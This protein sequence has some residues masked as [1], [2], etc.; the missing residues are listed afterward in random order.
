MAPI[1]SG[2]GDVL[3]SLPVMQALIERG[4][5]VFLVSRSFRQVGISERIIGL[6]GEVA[7]SE[8]E[9]LEGDRYLNLRDHPLQTDHIWGSPQFEEFFGPT[10]MEK[11]ISKIAVDFGV[12]TDFV[13]LRPLRFDR[14]ADLQDAVAF[15]PGTDGYYKHWL[16]ENWLALQDE[17]NCAG[18]RVIVA[19]KADESPAVARLLEAGC[20][21]LETPTA[22]QAIDLISSCV[23][24]V[25]VDTGLMHTAVQQG[26]PTYCFVHPRN[27]HKRSA[28]N[29]F[30]F[31][32]ADCP[33]KCQRDFGIKPGVAA[34]CSPE[35]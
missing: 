3:I 28:S 10:D 26:V 17:L 22:G 19:G 34:Q 18:L 6:K 4:E 14:R 1:G 15:V 16:H 20:E 11:I 7:E 21:C 23:A 27:H 8:L 12:E 5:N 31:A 13:R 30:N 29:C 35:I 32:A 25:S 24:V 9:L 33:E 2:F